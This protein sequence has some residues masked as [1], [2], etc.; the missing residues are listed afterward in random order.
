M[1]YQWPE[2]R[3]Q[4]VAIHE[5]GHAL[6]WAAHGYRVETVSLR[7]GGGQCYQ[8][9]HGKG[10]GPRHHIGAVSWLAGEAAER[11]IQGA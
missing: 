5:A 11:V 1:A 2:G 9:E 10:I 8:P 7:D 3:R 4:S 6:A